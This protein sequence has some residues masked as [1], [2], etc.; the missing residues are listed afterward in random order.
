MREAPYLALLL[1]YDGTLAPF[2]NLPELAAPDSSLIE[3]LRALAAR[4]RTEVH[5]TSGRS[6]ADLERWFGALPV[7]LHAEHGLWSRPPGSAS[8]WSSRCTPSTEWRDRVRPVLEHFS[9]RTPGAFVEEK[10][11][12]LAWHYR[13]VEPELADRRAQELELRLQEVLGEAPAEVIAGAKVI[14]LRPRG[15]NKGMVVPPLAAAM[16]AGAL[17]VALGDDRTDEDL[18]AA[19]PPSAIAI[20]V[21]PGPSLAAFRLAGVAEARQL[22]SELVA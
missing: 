11:A 13:R 7:G 15:V 21:G 16:P 5:V 14:E 17:I 18:F 1:D 22:L 12:S 3:L 20:H 2:A 9:A 19:L 8:E 4:P 6:R 10:T